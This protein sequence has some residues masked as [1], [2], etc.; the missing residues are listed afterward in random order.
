MEEFQAAAQQ[1]QQMMMLMMSGGANFEVKLF[2]STFVFTI[3]ANDNDFYRLDPRIQWVFDG[4][5][6]G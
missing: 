1:Q 2:I 6:R 3:A 4:S 5:M